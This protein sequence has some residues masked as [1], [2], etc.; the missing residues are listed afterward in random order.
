[1][2]HLYWCNDALYFPLCQLVYWFIL[3]YWI[4]WFL[5]MVKAGK[6][7]DSCISYGV[8]N[9]L[10]WSNPIP[11]TQTEIY[12]C[13]YLK[14]FICLFLERGEGREKEKETL[15]CGCLS[16][17]P[18][19]G[20]WLETQACA[21]TWNRI[22]DPLVPRLMINPL[23]YT[24]QGQTAIYRGMALLIFPLCINLIF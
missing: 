16:C 2:S 7:Q 17:A 10:S 22:C 24:S 13:I 11:S 6:P 15:M 18:L 9:H 4:H 14:Y 12:L 21:P 5:Q 19:L 3:Q 8:F 20:T 23:S 1:M